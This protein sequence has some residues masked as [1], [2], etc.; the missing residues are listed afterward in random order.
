MSGVPYGPPRKRSLTLAR[1][2][3]S[4]SIED[5]F[6]D[7]F[8]EI[9]QRE[10]LSLNALAARIDRQR[11]LEVGLATA[12]RLFVLHD[13]QTRQAGSAAQDRLRP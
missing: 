5:A 9:A 13:L 8:Q 12:I 2:R 6:W 10:G 4:V 3:T 1:H 11:G 7:G